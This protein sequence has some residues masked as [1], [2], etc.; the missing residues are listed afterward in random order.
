MTKLLRFAVA[1]LAV[2]GTTN[3][4][5]GGPLPDHPCYNVAD[6]KAQT[7]REAFSKCIKAH[8]EEA[9]ADA[10]CAAFRADKSAYLKAHGL[11]SV[12]ALFAPN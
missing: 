4:L 2:F 11:D 3:V 6:C 8:A 1:A 7:S 10:A 12:D 5:A 9:N